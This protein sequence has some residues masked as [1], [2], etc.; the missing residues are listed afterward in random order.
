MEQP[1]ADQIAA[2]E[3]L[4]LERWYALDE[5]SARQILNV[6]SA[7]DDRSLVKHPALLRGAVIASH[8]AELSG[9]T[10]GDHA[11]LLERFA[12][13]VENG[14]HAG[15]NVPADPQWVMMRMMAA[16]WRNNLP[17]AVELSDRLG[18]LQ[19]GVGIRAVLQGSEPD[20]LRPGQVALQRG[21]TA[22]LAGHPSAA[23]EL[24]AQAYRAGGLPP[25]KHFA[26]VNAA[27]N[28]AMLA[29]VEGHDAVAEKWLERLD[30][31]GPIPK[32][33]ADLLLVGAQIAKSVLATDTGD[34]GRATAAITELRRAGDRLE[35][36]PYVLYA[37]TAYDLAR[38]E[39]VQAFKRMKAV[40]FERNLVISSEPIADHLVFRAYL[41]T[42][43]AGGEGGLALRLAEDL[44]YPL[45]S[46]V[47]VARTRLLAGDN[48]AAAR[49]AARAMR[50]VLLPKR[51]MW[52]ATLVHA[53]AELRQGQRET[54]LRSFRLILAGGPA[55]LPSILGRAPARDIADLYELAGLEAPTGVTQPSPLSA[56][57]AALTARERGVLQHLSDGL[58]PAQIAKIDVTSEHTVRTHIKRIYR[59]LGVNSRDAA[60]SRAND[61][62][63]LR[64]AHLDGKQH[65][66]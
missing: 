48:A 21:L 19:Q 17:R 65:T 38:D 44:D 1:S 52:E 47:P 37:V 56:E 20:E 57:I 4:F 58:T 13:V 41:D 31:S 9:D 10:R 22:T 28:A 46:L 60:V 2:A 40:G 5:G 61:L 50:R 54:A 15:R 59:K 11:P 45:R 55:S 39:P 24:F 30:E 6:A 63:L 64:W 23:M 62:G 53:L 36:W 66:L 35:L 33:S 14:A 34:L 3:Q 7:L 18:S 51:D 26:S 8:L 29:A 42:L 43:V 49:V 25:Y 12:S 32:W 27:A 16:R